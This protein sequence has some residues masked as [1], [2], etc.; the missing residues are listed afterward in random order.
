MGNTCFLV[1][2]RAANVPTVAVRIATARKLKEKKLKPASG[3]MIRSHFGRLAPIVFENIGPKRDSQGRNHRK[4]I[5]VPLSTIGGV[6]T[7]RVTTFSFSPPS[8]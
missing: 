2:A 6:L 5:G 7:L 1:V 4:I 8:N 3:D